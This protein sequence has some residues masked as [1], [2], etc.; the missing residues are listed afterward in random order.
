MLPF[1]FVMF[2]QRW[3]KIDETTHYHKILGFQKINFQRPGNLLTSHKK[4]SVLVLH[5]DKTKLLPNMTKIL[6]M[7][8]WNPNILV[9][10]VV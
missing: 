6:K 9:S 5:G 7:Y 3:L 1:F 4:T 10:L 2:P 8:F